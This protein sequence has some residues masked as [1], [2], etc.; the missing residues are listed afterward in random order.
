MKISPNNRMARGAAAALGS[1]QK[2]KG[3]IKV[4]LDG[5]LTDAL[6]T[7]G[8]FGLSPIIGGMASDGSQVILVRKSDHPERPPENCEVLF[9]EG[10]LSSEGPLV[11]ST[12]VDRDGYWS[13]TC[14]DHFEG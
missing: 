12:I 13:I 5:S 8:E 4:K 14:G 2:V 1:L 6:L 7:R 10:E 11:A 9:L 3:T